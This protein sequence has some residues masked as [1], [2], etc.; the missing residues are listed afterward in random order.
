MPKLMVTIDSKETEV[1]T[2]DF[3]EEQTEAHNEVVYLQREIDRNNYINQLIE[4]R[5]LVLLQKLVSSDKEKA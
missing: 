4:K 1:Q 2:D 3:T 5:K